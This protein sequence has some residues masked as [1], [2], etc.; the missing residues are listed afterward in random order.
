MTDSKKV[1]DYVENKIIIDE[2]KRV[3]KSELSK[4]GQKFKG[5]NTNNLLNTSEFN[6]EINFMNKNSKHLVNNGSNLSTINTDLKLPQK[7][8]VNNIK[9]IINTNNNSRNHKDIIHED[10]ESD[11]NKYNLNELNRSEK[12]INTVNTTNTNNH[13]FGS[14]RLM[15]QGQT[16][17]KPDTN[18]IV[19]KN[20]IIAQAHRAFL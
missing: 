14:E 17:L 8:I 12:S 2:L 18:G 4:L 20:E 5:N 6:N 11:Q 10:Q 1:Y 7:I 9:Q 3:I 15:S 19:R 16:G 13:N